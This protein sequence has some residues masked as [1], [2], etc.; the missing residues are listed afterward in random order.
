V[1]LLID[2]PVAIGK[3]KPIFI[4]YLSIEVSAAPDYAQLPTDPDAL[5]CCLLL[6]NQ[7]R[8]SNLASPRAVR[9]TRDQMRTSTLS[10]CQKK[11]HQQ[12]FKFLID[13][14]RFAR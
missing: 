2:I 3:A 5:P 12:R 6:L 10:H 8:F 1:E 4:N 9:M 7:C 13:P 14:W 11:S